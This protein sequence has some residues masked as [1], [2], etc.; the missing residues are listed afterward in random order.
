MLCHI[1]FDSFHFI[2]G[3][4]VDFIWLSFRKPFSRSKLDLILPE[5]FLDVFFLLAVLAEG[6]IVSNLGTSSFVRDE[7]E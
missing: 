7:F 6:F 5:N 4:Y 3:V 2:L 1:L